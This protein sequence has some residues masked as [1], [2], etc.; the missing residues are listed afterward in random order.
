[1]NAT[2]G[3]PQ[4]RA[5][6]THLLDLDTLAAKDIL[7][8]CDRAVQLRDTGSQAPAAL[9]G[10]S[11]INLFFEGSTRTRSSFQLATERLGGRVLNFDVATSSTSKGETL[12]DTLK[13]LAAMSPDI[14]VVRHGT[15]GAAN[16]VSQVLGE[17]FGIVNAGDGWHAHPTQGLADILT[18]REQLGDDW[19]QR[20]VVILGDILHSRTARSLVKGLSSLGTRDIRTVGPRTLQPARFEGVTMHS[21]VE[22][23]LPGADVVMALRLQRERMQRHSIPSQREYFEL[24]GVT[25]ERLDLAAPGAILM[26]PGPIGRGGDLASAAADG[27]AS[28]IIEQVANGVA[29]RMAVLERIAGLLAR[30]RKKGG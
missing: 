2:A 29:M 12:L 16:F 24:W 3:K 10:M 19:A 23:A 14:F 17:G 27:P 20:R 15:S 1:M 4:D 26:H 5:L 7:G 13:T 6:P 25:P 9:Q 22:D 21:A 18:I 28:R 11:V 30:Q 8:L